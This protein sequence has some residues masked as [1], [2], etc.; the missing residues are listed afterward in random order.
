MVMARNL[1]RI[2]AQAVASSAH[3]SDLHRLTRDPGLWVEDMARFPMLRIGETPGRI[4]PLRYLA[5]MPSF[6]GEYHPPVFSGRRH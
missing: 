5:F 1:G 6:E 3:S 2:Q 4:E